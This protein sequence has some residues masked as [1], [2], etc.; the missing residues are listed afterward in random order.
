M[1]ARR[2]LCCS[3]GIYSQLPAQWEDNL[4]TTLAASIRFSIAPLLEPSKKAF[5]F[6]TNVQ[7]PDSFTEAL[8]F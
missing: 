2:G 8:D 6:F 5:V 4:T 3:E 7:P 1:L